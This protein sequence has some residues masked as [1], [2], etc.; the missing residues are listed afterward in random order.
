MVN[1]EVMDPELRE[2]GW[3]RF[4]FP[5]CK[6]YHLNRYRRDLDIII[7]KEPN[8]FRPHHLRPIL[9][10]DIKANIHNKHLRKITI[11]TS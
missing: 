3:H 10:F 1:T 9:M 5:W 11:K 6:G 7:H 8:D 4:N 2:I